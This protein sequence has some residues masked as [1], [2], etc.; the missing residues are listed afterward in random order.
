MFDGSDYPGSLDEGLFEDWL[1]KGRHSKI[2][3]SYLLIVWDSL[4]ERYQPAYIEHR[5]QIDSY[6]HHPYATGQ[7]AL[8]AVYDLYS[9]SRIIS[10]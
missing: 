10:S 3:Y 4:Y 2:P 7:E 6:E 5:S 9:E 8:V 1:D